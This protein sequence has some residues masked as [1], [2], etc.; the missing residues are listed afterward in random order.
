MILEGA[1]DLHGR[2]APSANQPLHKRLVE[3]NWKM[4]IVQSH[5]VVFNSPWM[6]DVF[7]CKQIDRIEMQYRNRVVTKEN[8]SI[9]H[10]GIWR[11]T[12]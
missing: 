6:D 10:P 1:L 11:I 5:S 4:I 3:V 9:F 12:K 8:I 7:V 2:I